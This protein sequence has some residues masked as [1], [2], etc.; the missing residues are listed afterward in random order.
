[1]D[2][3]SLQEALALLAARDWE[4]AH[5]IVQDNP[6]PLASWAHG[7]VHLIEGD[8]SNAR[9]WYRLA[10]RP[11]PGLLAI[12]AEIAALREALGPEG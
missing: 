6:A 5:A 11:F 8:E 12:D 9:Y 1:M 4:G 3:A 10:E 2:K 7:I